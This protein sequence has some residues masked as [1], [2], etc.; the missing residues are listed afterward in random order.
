MNRIRS[1]APPADRRGMTLVEMLVALSLFGVAM[2][3]IFG[4]L[5]SS[6]RSYSSMSARVET[7]QNIRAVLGL[8]SSEVRSAGCDPGQTG[9]TKL[10]LAGAQTFECRMDLNGNSAI[11]TTEPAEDV[12]YAYVTNTRELTRNSGGGAQVVLR[13]ITAVDFRY[14]DVTG[15]LLAARPLSAADRARVRFVEFDI[16]GES[17]RGELARYV[18]RV[19]VRNG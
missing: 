3:V 14:Y 19:F 10:P 11:E 2:G 8:M 5:T 18:T 1:E 6:R 15:A 13:G 4:F 16:T 9:F 7:Q 17:D 12:T